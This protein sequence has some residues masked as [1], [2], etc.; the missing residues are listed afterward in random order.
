MYA[1][2]LERTEVTSVYTALNTE[3]TAEEA[4]SALVPAVLAVDS[5]AVT[6]LV[7]VEILLVLAVMLFV[8]W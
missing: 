3:E 2:F 5:T 1:V 7:N 8:F 4:A 6:L